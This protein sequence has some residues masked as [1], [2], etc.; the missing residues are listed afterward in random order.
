MRVEEELDQLSHEKDML[1]A[2]GV[3]DGVHLGHRYLLSRLVEQAG[4]EGLLSGVVTFRQHPREVLSPGTELPYLTTFDQKVDLLKKEGIDT[5]VSLSFTPELA[6]LS[7][8]EFI[9]LL[10]KHLRMSGLVVGPDF[11]LGRGRE[12]NTDTLRQLGQELG[13]S[14]TVISPRMIGGEMVSSTAIRNALADGKMEKVAKLLGRP[15]GLQSTVT[16]GAGRGTGLGF[17]TANLE[18]D[19]RQALPPDG[20]Y[21][22]WAYADGQAYE[23]MT[24]IGRRP[25]FGENERS[26]EVFLLNYHGNLYNQ[27]MKV[28]IVARL[29]EEK[30]FDTVDELKKQI[31]E[32]VKRGK[33]ILSTR[34]KEPV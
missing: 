24:N 17:P 13:F 25:T 10:K 23:S 7:A 29:R 27:E 22:T 20:V 3:F 5:V 9:L 30:R 8:R 19:R 28:D 32:D 2:V 15:Y 14:M 6:R 18:M 16:T 31:A 11:T 1:L 21:A 34:N 33:A 12:G 4:Q 26:I